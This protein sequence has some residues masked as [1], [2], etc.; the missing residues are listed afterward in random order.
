MEPDDTK[1]FVQNIVGGDTFPFTYDVP[2]S[3]KLKG[4]Y[5][6][7]GHDL[8]D[9]RAGSIVA[10]EFQI[11]CRNFKATKKGGQEQGVLISPFRYLF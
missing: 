10:V 5:P 4:D 2:E 6:D 11:H 8:E 9:L 1:Y 3:S 7:P